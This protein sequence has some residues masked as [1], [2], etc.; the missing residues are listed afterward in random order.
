[1]I[2]VYSQCFTRL[3]YISSLPQHVGEKTSKAFHKL[4]QI[5]SPTTN[6]TNYRRALM[7]VQRKDPCIPYFGR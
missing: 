1:M 6:H 3:C 5:M 4:Q 2:V 7:G